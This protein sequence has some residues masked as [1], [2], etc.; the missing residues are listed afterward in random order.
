MGPLNYWTGTT[1][2][3]LNDPLNSRRDE[4]KASEH[5]IPRA[6]KGGDPT[7]T[8]GL[9]D[10]LKKKDRVSEA[11]GPEAPVPE[12]TFLRPDTHGPPALRLTPSPSPSPS[13]QLLSPTSPVENKQRRSLD[14]FRSSR[15]RSAS[16]SSTG[17]AGG[18]EHRRSMFHR[19]ELTS[20]N[21][22]DDLPAIE[23]ADAG[24]GEWEARAMLL[25]KSRPGSP[26][27][28]ARGAVATGARGNGAGAG[29]APVG[30]GKVD[31]DIQTAIRLHE[32]G[33]LESSTRLF[34][35]L[36]D[37]RGANNPLSQVLYGL[38]LRCVSFPAILHPR[39]PR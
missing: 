38:A 33:N 3:P 25:A 10:V 5:P 19:K 32:E 39:E 20:E 8:M 36:A 6:R 37:P 35:R 17:T 14:V 15:S 31:E 7:A 18:R 2:H 24:E 12:F 30:S 11:P 23:G 28:G 16:A 27:E 1:P 21:V 26:G 4:R 22:P 29:K 34:G 9:R 13:N